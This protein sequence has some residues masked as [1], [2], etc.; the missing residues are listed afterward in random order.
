MKSKFLPSFVLICSLFCI[1]FAQTTSLPKIKKG[2]N[3]KTVRVKMLKAGWKPAATANA[4]KCFEGDERCE[5][6][7][8]MESCAGTGKANCAFRWK[9]KNKVVMIFT[10][11]ENTIFSG[12]RFQ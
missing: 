9:R 3:Y 1:N 8:E 10:L 6:R 2:E 11:G 4:D 12:Y 7:P 5:G